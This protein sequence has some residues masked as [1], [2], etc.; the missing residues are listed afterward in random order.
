MKDFLE[1]YKAI[2]VFGNNRKSEAV[3]IPLNEGQV[4]LMFVNGQWHRGTVEKTEGDGFPLCVLL[5]QNVFQN[6]AVSNI[7][8]M[9]NAFKLPPPTVEFCKIDNFEN[10][11]VKQIA[12]ETI[13]AGKL[14]AVKGMKRDEDCI[15][16][17][18]A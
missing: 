8:P 9:P 5:D 11:T 6:I 1:L 15:I 10:E 16:V 4:C 18:I 14:V 2:N 13:K 7:I 17:T 3:G 12:S